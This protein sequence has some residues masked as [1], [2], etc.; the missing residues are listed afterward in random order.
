MFNFIPINPEIPAH[1]GRTVLDSPSSISV[2][3]LST[4]H[5]VL[6]KSSN[7]LSILA[8]PAMQQAKNSELVI[9]TIIK[10]G[11]LH[12]NVLH[13]LQHLHWQQAQQQ[14]ITHQGMHNIPKITNI[15]IGAKCFFILSI[16]SSSSP[17]PVIRF[18]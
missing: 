3:N 15:T 14:N 17:S 4:E 8:N 2:I 11:V 13:H 10:N 7:V 6:A 5:S 1:L 18:I 12:F 9:V 16:F